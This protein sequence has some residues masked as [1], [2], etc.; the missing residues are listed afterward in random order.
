M[1]R[2]NVVTLLTFVGTALISLGVVLFAT[3]PANTL[4]AD[5]PQDITPFEDFA[6]LDCH[7]DRARLTELATEV[8]EEEEAELSSG[9]G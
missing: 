4:Y 9:P 3:K 8:P 6:C 5:D 1:K 7:T 2:L